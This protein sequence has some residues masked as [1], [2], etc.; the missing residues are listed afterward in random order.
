MFQWQGILAIDFSESKAYK[1]GVF[2]LKLREEI[3]KPMVSAN[4]FHWVMPLK[5]GIPETRDCPRPLA[6]GN[7][8][9]ARPS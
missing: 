9:E 5:Q 7:A 3:Q 8:L 2:F 1:E 4:A 6:L